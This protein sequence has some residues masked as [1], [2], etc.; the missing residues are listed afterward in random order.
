MSQIEAVAFAAGEYDKLRVILNQTGCLSSSTC[1]AKDVHAGYNCL[2]STGKVQCNNGFID[3]I[4][5]QRSNLNG[6]LPTEIG[7]LK[8]LAYL[9][10][11]SNNL[12]G[13]VPSELGVLTALRSFYL[14]DNNFSGNLPSEL[15][16]CP[17]LYYLDLSNNSLT[18][19]IPERSYQMWFVSKLFIRSFHM[20]NYC[21]LQSRVRHTTRSQLFRLLCHAV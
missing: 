1:Q 21:L 17:V 4:D 7:L 10:V 13:T 5:I 16:L 6:I 9:N 8:R 20:K 3:H 18:G 15:A 19:S 11:K 14:T 2:S 12:Y